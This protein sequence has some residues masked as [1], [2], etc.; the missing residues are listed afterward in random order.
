MT[1]NFIDE[2][3]KK[4]KDAGVKGTTIE[5]AK[6]ETISKLGFDPWS[7]MQGDSAKRQREAA[8]CAGNGQMSGEDAVSKVKEMVASGKWRE[9][10]A[11]SKRENSG[12]Y[13]DRPPRLYVMKFIIDGSERSTYDHKE[14][15][16]AAGYIHYSGSDRAGWVPFTLPDGK[17]G[18]GK[19][20]TDTLEIERYW[21]AKKFNEPTPT[22]DGTAFEYQG[23]TYSVDDGACT[24]G[25]RGPNGPRWGSNHAGD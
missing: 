19:E 22:A 18:Q 21:T 7:A 9:V 6:F 25:P 10:T 1:T 12:A 15:I 11:D 3:F 16:K 17:K 20:I 14:A 23:E 2:L 8:P 13:A 5:G 4:L 24:W